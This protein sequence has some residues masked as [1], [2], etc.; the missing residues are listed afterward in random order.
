MRRWPGRGQEPRAKAALERYTLVAAKEFGA[1]GIT[2][3]VVSPGATATELFI[4]TA[5]REIQERMMAASPLGRLGDP[6]DIADVVAFLVSDRARW[7]TGKNIRVDG[8]IT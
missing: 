5:P 4:A 3:N 7:I 8:G 6:E 1:R 2:A